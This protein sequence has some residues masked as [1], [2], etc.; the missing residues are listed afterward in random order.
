MLLYTSVELL[1]A[2]RLPTDDDKGSVK[3]ISL[4]IEY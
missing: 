3:K 4:G 1:N 2:I